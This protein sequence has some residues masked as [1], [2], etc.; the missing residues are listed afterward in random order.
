MRELVQQHGPAM[1]SGYGTHSLRAALFIWTLQ[2]AAIEGGRA[3]CGRLM[4]EA[5]TL[6][7]GE[8]DFDWP[9][10][11]SVVQMSMTRMASCSRTGAQLLSLPLWVRIQPSG[12][13]D[14][15]S[16]SPSCS[17]SAA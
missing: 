3:K 14:Y 4:G 15:W 12:I 7:S 5:Y 1:G 10:C 17:Y 11:Q 2:L 13:S 6:I 8:T 9:S 16:R